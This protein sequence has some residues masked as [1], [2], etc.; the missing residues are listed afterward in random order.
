[1]SKIY[2]VARISTKKQN[3]ERQVRNILAE[4]SNA[5]IVKETYTGVKL[6]GRKEFENLVNKLQA[7][8]TLVFDSVSRMSRNASEGYK[9]YE[10]LFNKNINLVFLKEAHINTSVFRQALEN[11]I[12]IEIEIQ[13]EDVNNFVTG[14]V[15]LLNRYTLA[16]AK[17]QI[18]KAFE[19]AEKEVQDLAI[20]Q[21][22]PLSLCVGTD[23]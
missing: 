20:R 2:G 23:A 15:D 11:Q 9:L 1:M 3:I 7:G 17:K 4:Y 22:H 19:Q 14:L 10:E 18:E 12:K 13:D 6:E 8:D 21:R 16:L 5:I